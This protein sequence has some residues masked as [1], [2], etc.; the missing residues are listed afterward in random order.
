MWSTPRACAFP[1][2]GKP[3]VI[4]SKYCADHINSP[5][6]SERKYD[7]DRGKNDR[8]RHEYTLA[9]WKKLSAFLR[10][11]NPI[12]QRIKRGVRCMK[13]SAVVHHL[14][15][16]YERLDLMHVPTNCVAL[17]ADCHPGGTA[18]T[19]HW[20]PNVDFVPTEYEVRV[21]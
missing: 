20:Q 18:G 9:R 7:R 15:S 8:T 3:T 11:R 5:E 12:C 16:P 10:R 2:C 6:T 13:P 4:G 17:C 1:Q 14:I 19:P 21:A